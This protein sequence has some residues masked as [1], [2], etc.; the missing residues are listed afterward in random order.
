MMDDLLTAAT[1]AARRGWHVFPI[2]P[3]GKYP[4]R[5]FTRWEHNAT[6][7]PNRLATWWRRA[8]Y[9]VGIACGPSGLL[10]IDLDLPKPGEQPPAAYAARGLATGEH[11]FRDLCAEHGQPYPDDTFTVRTRR[12]G[13]HLYFTAPP[14][15]DLGNTTGRRGNGLGWLI[16][17]R[18]RGGYVVAPGSHVA[19]RDGTG[20]YTLTRDRPP[21]PLPGWLAAAL[22]PPPPP[23]ATTTIPELLASLP[24]RRLSAYGHAALTGEVE[25]VATAPDGGRNRA[26]NLAAWKLGKLIARGALPRDLVEHALQAAAE[27]AN[28]HSRDPR[29]PHTL[30]A[31]IGYGIDAGIRAA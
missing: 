25:R 19:A 21:A 24:A 30:A 5:G 4:A 8:P 26:L 9:N 28:R 7:D 13:T 12:G 3:G 16:D 23:P 11:V 22:T 17:T 18:A 15:L 27:T 10:V 2:T 20:P 31:V 14:G 29:P 6:T 1:A